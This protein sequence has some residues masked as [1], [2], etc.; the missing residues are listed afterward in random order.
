MNEPNYTIVTICNR[1][2]IENYYCLEQWKQSVAGTNYMMIQSVGSLYQGLCDKPKFVY[3]AIKQGFINTEFIIFC[4][5]WDLVF[6]TTPEEIIERFLELNCDLV[7]SAEKNCFP[8]DLKK[9]YDNLPYTS[10]YRYLN[11][12][13]IVGYTNKL[14]EILEVMEVEKIP[15]DYWDAE[16][17]CNIHFNDQFEY[18]KIF[19]NQPVNIKLDYQ[20]IFSR[21]L[22]DA[23]LEE[24][25]FSE[26]RIRNIET[27]SYPCTFHMNGNGKTENGIRENILKHLNL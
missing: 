27:N 7:I 12:G 16:K 6:A 4:D 22:H 24:L 17:H 9:E 26:T 25:D 8:D 11:S 21:T 5:S 19:L 3:R 15:N 10:S 20:Q 23:K 18:Q 14:L 13:M 1:T 2:P